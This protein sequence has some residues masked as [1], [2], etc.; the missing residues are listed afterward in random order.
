MLADD[1]SISNKT[2]NILKTLQDKGIAISLATGKIYPSVQELV[3]LLHITT[4]LILSNGAV[5]QKPDGQLVYDAYLPADV[6][7]VILDGYRDYEADLSIFTPN[8]I[9]VE[10]E[11]FN[12]EHITGIFKEK[13]QVIGDW[14]NIKKYF[15]SVCKTLIINRYSQE[16]IDKLEIYLRENLN[17]KVT[18]STGAPN[19]I[20]VMPYGVSKQTGLIHLA[21]HLQISMD[22]VMVFGDHI[23][24]FGMLEIAGVAIA[25]GNAIDEIKKISDFV[26]GTNNEDGPAEFLQDYFHL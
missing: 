11:N 18:L 23:N 3:K 15:S 20:E 4:P 12:T 10:E 22:G 17:G 1:Q 19:S 14:S 9:F 25:V 26:I 13:I 7:Q 24:D 6:I 2:I 5:I 8:E 21:E 16:M